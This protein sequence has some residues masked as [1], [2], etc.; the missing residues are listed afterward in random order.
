MLPNSDKTVCINS[1]PP[2]PPHSPDL[3]GCVGA[4]VEL[5]HFHEMLAKPRFVKYESK[6]WFARFFLSQFCTTDDSSNNRTSGRHPEALTDSHP[7]DL[8]RMVQHSKKEEKENNREREPEAH[9]KPNYRAASPATTA[10]DTIRPATTKS[11]DQQRYDRIS[12]TFP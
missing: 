12:H 8:N 1:T 2:Q 6:L 9:E 4:N 11:G 5:L 3:A 7:K 10:L